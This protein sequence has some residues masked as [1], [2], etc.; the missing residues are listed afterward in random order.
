LAVARRDRSGSPTHIDISPVTGTVV[1]VQSLR[2]SDDDDNYQIDLTPSASTAPTTLPATPPTPD[3]PDWLTTLRSHGPWDAKHDPDWDLMRQ[4]GASDRPDRVIC[5]AADSFPPHT[6]Q[7]SLAE[8]FASD[9]VAGVRH[10]SRC[11]GVPGQVAIARGPT[12]P[13]LAR[14]CRDAG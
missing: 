1:A 8:Q 9:L 7:T 5:V 3:S 11:L 6:A 4:L 10:L 14:A 2:S 12:L 13:G